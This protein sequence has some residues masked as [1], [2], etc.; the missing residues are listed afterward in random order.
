MKRLLLTALTVGLFLLTVF[1]AA[2]SG[3]KIIR[4][5]APA[6]QQTG[7]PVK[8]TKAHPTPTPSGATS[9][10]PVITE[11]DAAGLKKLLHRDPSPESRPL[12]VNFWATWCEPCREEFPDL[13][14]I[15]A[16]YRARGLQFA[17]ISVDDTAELGRAVPQFLQEMHATKLSVYLLNV[18]EPEAAV[19]IVDPTWEGSLPATFLYDAGGQIVYKHTGRI[20]PDELRAAIDRLLKAK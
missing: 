10:K 2:Q 19:S 18:A 15:D 3:P 9:D 4:G 20:E 13:V 17:A 8:Q 12:L 14:S 1:D 5:S 16:D 11:L 6:W 7:S